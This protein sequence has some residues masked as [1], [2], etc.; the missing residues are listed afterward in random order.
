MT[1]KQLISTGVPAYVLV[2]GLQRGYI[3]EAN[4]GV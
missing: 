1:G 2:N 3:R 4:P